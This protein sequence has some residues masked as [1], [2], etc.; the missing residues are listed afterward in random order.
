MPS[1]KSFDVIASCSQCGNDGFTIVRHDVKSSSKEDLVIGLTMCH[2][3]F[4][5]DMSQFG[6]ACTKCKSSKLKIDVKENK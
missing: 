1:D 5:F 4:G 2:R 6:F 3:G